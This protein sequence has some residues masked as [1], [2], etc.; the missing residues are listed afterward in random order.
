[1]VSTQPWGACLGRHPP[2]P[3][4]V[5]VFALFRVLILNHPFTTS[6]IPTR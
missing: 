5:P 6:L 4:I 2:Y 3:Q 1:M